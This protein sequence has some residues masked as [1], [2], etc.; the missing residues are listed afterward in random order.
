MTRALMQARCDRG[1]E[2]VLHARPESRDARRRSAG[3]TSTG[4]AAASRAGC[5]ARRSRCSARILCLAQ[6]VEI[7][8]A[9]GGVGAAWRVA[10]RRR[11]GWF[12]PALVDALATLP[13]TTAFW[14]SLRDADIATWE[15][16]D[17]LLTADDAR[18]DQIAEA[19]AGVVD[20]KSPWTYRH[21][22]RVCLI[23][24]GLASAFGA[25]E[26]GRCAT[27][28]APRCCTTSA[29]SRSPTASSTSPA[30]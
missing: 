26:R 16:P 7:F 12:D 13:R 10:R 3:S 1:A 21:S 25:D 14:R 29:S 15:P 5:A 28:A 8:H 20:A 6:T 19:F 27:C 24:I 11:G 18:L 22:D 4:T 9:A 30:R 23:V 17:R 2:I